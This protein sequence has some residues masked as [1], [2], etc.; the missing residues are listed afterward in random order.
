M[1]LINIRSNCRGNTI[2]NSNDTD[3]TD[4]YTNDIR[5]DPRI[6]DCHYNDN[7]I[8]ARHSSQRKKLRSDSTNQRQEHEDKVSQ[9][10]S[11]DTPAPPRIKIR[12]KKKKKIA[13]SFIS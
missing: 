8:E 9:S 5:A 10:E 6:N 12:K 4:N 3:E 2:I 1:S 7:D 11:Q 13:K